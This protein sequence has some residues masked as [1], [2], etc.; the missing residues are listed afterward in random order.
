MLYV[1]KVKKPYVENVWITLNCLGIVI[2][3]NL[4]I[5]VETVQTVAALKNGVMP[6]KPMT[7]TTVILMVLVVVV[8]IKRIDKY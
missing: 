7:V 3:M 4:W 8:N 5:V 1:T 2:V 6:V